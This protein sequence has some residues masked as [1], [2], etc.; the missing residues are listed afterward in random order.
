MI[1]GNDLY[2]QI[3]ESGP[4]SGTLL[5][6]LSKLKQEGEWKRLVQECIRAL[7]IHP[8]DITIRRLLAE[9]YLETGFLTQAEAE[10]EKVTKQ[11]DELASAYKHLATLY[12]RG[13]REEEAIK[14]LTLY[15]AHRPDDQEAQQLLEELKTLPEAEPAEQESPVEAAA[16]VYEEAGPETGE[17]VEE[18]VEE[19][20][21]PPERK[22]T[23]EIA[24]STLAEL[25]Y[26]QGQTHEAIRTYEKVVA[27][28]PGDARAQ[29]R[30]EEL[31][32]PTP[33]QAVVQRD[34]ERERKEKMIALLEK[35][36]S[37]I[38]EGMK[39]AMPA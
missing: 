9:A 6:V 11:M 13:K 8:Q 32:A 17:D 35:W 29:A 28:N 10:W 30:L 14:A 21:S 38:Q 33:P 25:Y 22:D 39:D 36:L 12:H 16:P 2:Q 34:K 26:A 31:K 24:T 7:N 19:V 15:L 1:N 37:N 18:E 4:S 3:L 23:P 5:V 27:E 20:A